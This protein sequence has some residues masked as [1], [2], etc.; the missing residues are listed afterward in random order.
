MGGEL[1]DEVRQSSD[2]MGLCTDGTL[3]VPP[4][5]LQSHLGFLSQDGSKPPESFN[6]GK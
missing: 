4:F 6:K 1:S 3:T 5:H 2:D